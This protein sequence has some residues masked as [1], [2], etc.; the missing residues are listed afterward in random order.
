MNVLIAGGGGLLGRELIKAFLNNGDRVKAYALREEE[1]AGLPPHPQLVT[2]SCDLTRPE[3]LDGICEGMDS[4]IS[5][6]GITRISTRLKHMDVDYQ[7]N[8]NLL[9]EAEKSGVKTFGFISPQGTGPDTGVPLFEAK[10]QFEEKL[11][12]SS[13]NQVL[14]H[15]GGFFPDLAEYS[16]MAAK[17]YMMVFG[18][19]KN[20]FTPVSVEDLAQ[21]MTDEMQNT[22]PRT[23][24]V[25]GPEDLSWNEI[26]ISALHH[27]GKA[28]RVIHIPDWI[29]RLTLALL[30]PLSPHYYA[31]GKLIHY[32]SVHDL[33]SEQRGQ[34]RFIDY[35]NG[36]PK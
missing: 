16:Q 4:V 3:T 9:K 14:F 15:A 1:F 8:L 23:V 12:A 13:I 5:T 35:L 20:R 31:M 6:I 25:G 10:H 21:V 2:G 22:T 33:L 36:I 18:S 17:G 34:Q 28:P 11:R 24:S 26:C 7:G 19:G 29:S 30:K 32:T 27:Y